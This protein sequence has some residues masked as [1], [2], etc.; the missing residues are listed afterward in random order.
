MMFFFATRMSRPPPPAKEIRSLLVRQ[1]IIPIVYRSI[2]HGLVGTGRV[3]LARQI[4][5]GDSGGRL[6]A[7]ADNRSQ[8]HA[9]CKKI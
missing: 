6:R 4:A 7:A 2:F 3:A 1:Q 8:P 5:D 9:N